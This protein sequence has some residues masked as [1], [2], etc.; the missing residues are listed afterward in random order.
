V[1][2]YGRFTPIDECYQSLWGKK[3][4]IRVKNFEKNFHRKFRKMEMSDIIAQRELID[5]LRALM[6]NAEGLQE[7]ISREDSL[8]VKKKKIQFE[9][10]KIFL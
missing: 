3:R 7:I 4:K 5:S 9:K 6:N 8:T 2:Q 10:K 1:A